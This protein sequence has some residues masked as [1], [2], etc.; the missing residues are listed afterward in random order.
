MDLPVE[1]Y[2]ATMTRY[3]GVVDPD[4]ISKV[5]KLT[6][7]EG[8]SILHW[9]ARLQGKV[10]AVNAAADLDPSITRISQEEGV[11]ILLAGLAR[12]SRF[13]DLLRDLRPQ[14]TLA[15]GAERTITRISQ[16]LNQAYMNLLRQE[17]EANKLG[18]SLRT[19]ELVQKGPKAG[20]AS[21]QAAGQQASR[22]SSSSDDNRVYFDRHGS[23][24][25]VLAGLNRL[26]QS[27]QK[28]MLRALL[29]KQGLPDSMVDSAAAGAAG[30]GGG[31]GGGQGAGGGLRQHQMLQRQA[32]GAAQQQGQRQRADRADAR[33]C[34]CAEPRHGP[35]NICFVA[36]PQLAYA[37]WRPPRRGTADY[38]TYEQNCRQQGLQVAQ[39][40]AAQ[41]GAAGG[42]QQW[43]SK[44]R[45]T[46]LP[47]LPPVACAWQKGKT[48]WGCASP[49]RTVGSMGCGRR[50]L[51]RSSCLAR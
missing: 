30:A 49:S 9:S 32:G 50:P 7:K 11:L 3:F 4:E 26:D 33:P 47:S 45:K 8:E 51:E 44:R 40:G 14:L 24:R 21:G 37:G 27:T 6:L 2:W 35:T 36:N 48:R 41:P 20:Q 34:Q 22:A 28:A 23:N 42:Q 15:T 18:L 1:A 39:Q 25:S 43:R 38:A 46:M 16:K 19:L 31:A 12:D 17:E 5:R 10:D 29:K 13:A